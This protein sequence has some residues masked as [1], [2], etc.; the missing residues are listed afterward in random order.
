[1]RR[2]RSARSRAARWRPRRAARAPAAQTSLP[3]Q[4]KHHSHIS[5][6]L[7]S[8]HTSSYIPQSGRERTTFASASGPR[9]LRRYGV[10]FRIWL[11]RAGVVHPRR[12]SGRHIER[13]AVDIAERSARLRQEHAEGSEHARRGVARPWCEA[14]RRSDQDVG[15][16]GEQV[17]EHISGGGRG[18]GGGSGGGGVGVD[19]GGGLPAPCGRAPDLK[20]HP[21]SR[22]TK[23]ASHHLNLG[24]IGAVAAA[25]HV[26]NRRGA[27]KRRLDGLTTS[28]S[29]LP[30]APV[31]RR[32]KR[33]AADAALAAAAATPH[34]A[35]QRRR[36]CCPEPVLERGRRP[37]QVRDAHGASLD[38]GDP[39]TGGHRGAAEALGQEG[40]TSRDSAARGEKAADGRGGAP[41]DKKLPAQRA[42]LD[43][44]ARSPPSEREED[45]GRA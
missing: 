10:I 23:H 32:V 12:H 5:N 16:S 29:H 36:V 42:R 40:L 43:G 19:V 6:L 22:L 7:I 3:P 15:P 45:H 26:L 17:E 38:V 31:G 24:A 39:S 25:H 18:R 1:M 28:A 9:D 33:V 20:R 2:A 8:P 34:N 30:G 14:A 4:R 11:R 41:G 37:A 27:A 35:N 13:L 21:R 44:Q